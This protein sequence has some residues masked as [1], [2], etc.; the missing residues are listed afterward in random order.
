MKTEAR[1]PLSS[2]DA[3]SM[4]VGLTVYLLHRIS[5]FSLSFFFFFFGYTSED[6]LPTQFYVLKDFFFNLNF[7]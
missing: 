1:D 3:C 2:I 7:F 6:V 4:T 5:A